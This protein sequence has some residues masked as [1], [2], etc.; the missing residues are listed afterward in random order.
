MKVPG[1]NGKIELKHIDYPEK[2]KKKT[3]TVSYSD[4]EEKINYYNKYAKDMG[5]RT[6]QALIAKAL[7]VYTHRNKNPND[8]YP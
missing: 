8:K 7:H 4:S 6:I 5:F 2:K 3:K 1:R